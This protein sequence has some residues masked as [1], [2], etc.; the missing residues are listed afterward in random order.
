M[1][2]WGTGCALWGHVGPQHWQALLLLIEMA[3][4]PAWEPWRAPPQMALPS[5]L[6]GPPL[7][8]LR[9]RRTSLRHQE[10][11]TKHLPWSALGSSARVPLP[12]LPCHAAGRT[13]G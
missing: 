1:Q 6:E 11:R 12:P 3:A 7:A 4:L 10:T 9:H 5:W 13:Q 2:L 8:D